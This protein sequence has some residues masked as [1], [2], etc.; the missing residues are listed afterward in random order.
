MNKSLRHSANSQADLNSSMNESEYVKNFKDL[1]DTIDNNIQLRRQ[2]KIKPRSKQ[3]RKSVLRQIESDMVTL[4]DMMKNRKDA[5]QSALDADMFRRASKFHTESVNEKMK[6]KFLT[7]L[8]KE[9]GKSKEANKASKKFSKGRR[10]RSKR[11]LS[12]QKQISRDNYMINIVDEPNGMPK[13]II[14]PKKIPSVKS[15]E[16]SVE[17]PKENIDESPKL[18]II[19]STSSPASKKPKN[20]MLES[21]DEFSP[22]RRDP[23]LNNSNMQNSSKEI[24]DTLNMKPYEKLVYAKNKHKNHHKVKKSNKKRTKSNNL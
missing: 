9:Y 8:I 12:I 5:F 18:N 7:Y 21:E 6:A 22:E 3:Q 15:N 16:S 17:S 24:E 11:K 4:T 23:N 2:L 19:P 10:R 14:K 1:V 20:M 13:S